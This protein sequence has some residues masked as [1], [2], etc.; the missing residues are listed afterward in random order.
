[1]SDLRLRTDNNHIPSLHCSAGEAGGGHTICALLIAALSLLLGGPQ[2]VNPHFAA[3][4]LILINSVFA[5]VP[6]SL[7]MCVKVGS[8]YTN[9]MN[10]NYI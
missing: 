2:I 8:G 1:M 5:T 9:L 3:D 10:K 4:F 6:F 7:Y